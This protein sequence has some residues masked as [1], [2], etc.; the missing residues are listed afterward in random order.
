VDYRAVMGMIWECM[1]A[2]QF[3]G[4]A[5]SEKFLGNARIKTQHFIGASEWIKTG[6]GEIK[7]YH[8]MRVAHQKYK[9][10]ELS[11]V[12]YKG[13]AHGKATIHY[14]RVDGVWK[15]AGLEPDIRWA[16]HDYDKIFQED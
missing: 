6:E 13:H 1:P 12:L 3:V 8:Q 2:E 9:D 16:E 10:D 14:R 7:G 15:F 11:E 4:M 5:S